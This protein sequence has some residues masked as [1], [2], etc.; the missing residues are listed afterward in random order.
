MAKEGKVMEPAMS[1]GV[2]EGR[3]HVLS[4]N[5]DTFQIIEIRYIP[6]TE[7]ELMDFAETAGNLCDAA[8]L[9]A[10]EI[11]GTSYSTSNSSRP[12]QR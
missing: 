10:R 3:Y 12:L 9:K 1:I 6:D 5:P 8:I 11:V 7:Q 2:N 4:F